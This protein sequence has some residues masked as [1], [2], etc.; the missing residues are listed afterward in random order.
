M[1]KDSSKY[2]Y[3]C[4]G[5]VF[6][7]LVEFATALP[8]MSDDAYNFHAERGD[9]SNWLTSVVKKK[10]LAKKLNGADKAKAVKLL[11]KYAKKPKRK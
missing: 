3:A 2:F 10:D 7:S 5:Q 9:W 6:R 1:I 8:G 4:D 11:K